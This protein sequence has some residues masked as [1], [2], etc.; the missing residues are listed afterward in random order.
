MYPTNSTYTPTY[1]CD[2]CHA[3]A[4]QPP[5]EHEV[6]HLAQRLAHLETLARETRSPFAAMPSSVTAPA[7]SIWSGRPTLGSYAPGILSAAG[8]AAFWGYAVLHSQEVAWYGTQ[9]LDV[10]RHWLAS[11]PLPVETALLS[12]VLAWLESTTLTPPVVQAAGGCLA[13][14]AVW[15]F[16]RRVGRALRTSYHLTTEA[17]YLHTG[18]ASNQQAS[19]PL[20]HLARLRLRQSLRGRLLGYG[21]CRFTS[22]QRGVP[23][24][25]WRGVP[26][27]PLTSALF[28]AMAQAAQE[29]GRARR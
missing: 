12:R 14:S 5:E 6:A 2:V 17:L 27:R 16:W 20:R 26:L 29:P 21:R 13:L 8:W 25:V 15:V 18:P 9:Q 22:S 10:L 7:L 28:Q 1:T 3:T 24:M 4:P 23:A 19:L 11:G